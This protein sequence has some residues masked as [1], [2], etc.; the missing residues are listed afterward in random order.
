MGLC[1]SI[2]YNSISHKIQMPALMRTLW[3]T[4]P[5]Q[6][7][8]TADWTWLAPPCSYFSE[9]RKS[10]FAKIMVHIILKFILYFIERIDNEHILHKW[11]VRFILFTHNSL[12]P[13]RIKRNISCNWLKSIVVLLNTIRVLVRR[14]L[15]R[16]SHKM[17]SKLQ[18]CPYDRVKHK[19][20]LILHS[21][22]W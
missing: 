17:S 4:A 14:S 10:K 11:E 16:V 6:E 7:Q 2:T 8:N 18:V 5:C 15:C 9:Q 3:F 13:Q 1:I 19:I 20:D 12:Q 22:C 21:Y